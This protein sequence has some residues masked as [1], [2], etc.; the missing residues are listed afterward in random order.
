[1]RVSLR[2]KCDM[3]IDNKDM[4]KSGLR[5]ENI[6]IQVL[7][8]YIYMKNNKKMDLGRIK[9]CKSIIKNNTSCFSYFRNLMLASLA[10]LLSLE[11][12][13]MIYFRNVLEGYNTIIKFYDEGNYTPLSAYVMCEYANREEEYEKMVEKSI[14]ISQKLLSR[15]IIDINLNDGLMLLYGMSDSS[16]GF[17][18]NECET[19]INMLKKYFKNKSHAEPIG[20]IVMFSKKDYTRKCENTLNAV[21]QLMDRNYVYSSDDEL[22]IISWLVLLN[23][24]IDDVVDDVIE[25]NKYLKKKSSFGI[26]I[27]KELR[28]LYAGAIVGMDYI[29]KNKKQQNEK[30]DIDILENKIPQFILQSATIRHIQEKK[31][32]V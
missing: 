6:T 27:G 3:F 26:L 7:C 18:V 30:I 8:A 23:D 12:N 17:L 24:D 2:E 28:Q 19:C 22:A 16:D 21:K 10:T 29:Y 20:Q 11:E 1:M 4:A 25:V 32:R 5:W 14:T 31:G 13:P 9:K 15:S